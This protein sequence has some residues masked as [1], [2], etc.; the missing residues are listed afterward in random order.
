[1]DG[2]V[3]RLSHLIAVFP[4]VVPRC[5]QASACFLHLHKTLGKLGLLTTEIPD[6]L[7][8]IVKHKAS[9]HFLREAQEA[10]G[11]RFECRGQIGKKDSQRTKK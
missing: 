6:L 4:S 8:S 5:H 1:M 11:D 2:L 3:A 9:S 10:T 7:R